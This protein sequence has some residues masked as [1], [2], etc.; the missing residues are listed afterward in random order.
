M[1]AEFEINPN[2]MLNMVSN[3]KHTHQLII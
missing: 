2:K 1:V 3:Y